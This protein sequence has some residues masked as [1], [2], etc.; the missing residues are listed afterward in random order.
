MACA[1]PWPFAECT[2]SGSAAPCFRFVSSTRDSAGENDKIG[3]V[4]QQISNER[5][6]C[7]DVEFDFLNQR[8]Y[9]FCQCYETKSRYFLDEVTEQLGEK[10]FLPFSRSSR[11]ALWIAVIV[12]GGKSEAARD[13]VRDRTDRRAHQQKGRTARLV[14]LCS[15]SSHSSMCSPAPRCPPARCR[16]AHSR[17]HPPTNCVVARS[18]RSCHCRRCRPGDI[19]H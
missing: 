1:M 7:V 16:M 8:I 13:V 5:T 11:E 2:E 4:K 17:L 14:R 3:T 15:R 18:S 6:N 12:I 19:G 10:R 9:H